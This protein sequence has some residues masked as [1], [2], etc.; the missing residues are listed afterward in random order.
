MLI[1]VD[2]AIRADHDELRSLVLEAFDG[3]ELGGVEVRLERCRGSADSFT[4]RAY[5]EPP[6]RPRPAEGTE[7]LVRLMV[8]SLM[9]NR[10]YPKTYRYR[11]RSTAPW[12]TVHDWRERLVALAA[13]E[14]YHVVQFRQGLRRSE[15]VAERWAERV[16]TSWRASRT[17]VVPAGRHLALVVDPDARAAA[18]VAPDR[19]APQVQLS[20]FQ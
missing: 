20:L 19:S 15:V 11:G 12:I 18:F 3:V 13:H 2:P 6:R 4:G 14:A 16:L 8:P 7:Y 10:A 5:P 17:G 1:R 9:R